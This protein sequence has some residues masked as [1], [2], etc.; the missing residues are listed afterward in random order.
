MANRRK[1]RGRVNPIQRYHDRIAGRYDAIYDDEYWRWHD[2]VTWLHLKR[3]LPRDANASVIDLG[4][5]TGKWGLRLL[6][7]GY[8]VTFVDISIKML[9]QA[10]LKVEQAGMAGRA[11][12]QQADLADLAALPAERF[13]L[14]V[15][16]GDPL[17]C[18]ESL[19][20]GLRQVRRTLAVG[21]LL[22]A[23][24]DHL[25]AGVDYFL[26]RADLDGLERFLR[27]GRSHWLTADKAEQFP[28][29]SYTPRQVQ[30]AVQ[31]AGMEFLELI[32]KT[33]LPLRQYRQ[34]LADPAAFRRLV[35]LEASLNRDPAMLGRCSHLQFVARR[36]D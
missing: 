6:K 12:F 2:A 5:G 15:A 17:S 11:E 24:V 7:A 34:L 26:E 28:T 19:V 14:A 23:T 22:V 18:V 10:R 9:E 4:C 36:P 3:F 8:R 16:M 13:A 29:V 20:R 21:G 32:G 33:V 31:R 1:R 35:R 25:P 27:T 30:A